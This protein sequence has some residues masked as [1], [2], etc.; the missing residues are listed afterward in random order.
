MSKEKL[1]VWLTELSEAYDADMIH[2]ERA[3]DDLGMLT[4]ENQ[5]PEDIKASRDLAGKPCITINGMPQ[6][7]RQVTGQI[8]SMNPGVR[9]MAGDSDA[10]KDVAEILEGLIRQIEYQCDASS[11]YEGATESAA[12]CSIGHWRILTRFCDGDTFD[13][14]IEIKRIHNPFAV[15]WDP[16]A[17]DATRKDARYCYIVEDL[18]KEE[19]QKLY[20]GKSENPATDQH[21]IAMAGFW[22]KGE[23]VTIAERYW[24]EYEE[25]KIGLMADGSVVRNPTPPMNPVK[26]RTV[27]D[28]K[29]K[30]VKISGG[31][32]LEGP[33]DIAGP[34]IPVVAVVG[35][36]WHLGEATYRSS[37]IR[38]AKDPQILYNYARS[39]GAE[40]LGMQ[41][42]TPYMVTPKQVAGLEAIWNTANTV[43]APY[44]P[45][46][47]DPAAPAPQRIQPPVPS[48]AVLSE[49]QLA[50]E[51]MK[52]TTGIY[53][54]SLGN[55]S[56]ETSGVAINARK[57]ESQNSNSIY[58]DNMVKAVAHTGRILVAMIPKVYDTKRAVRILGEDDQEKI[59]VINDLMLTADGVQPVNDV[60]I[61]KYD[62]RIGV[63]PSYQ[64]KRQEASEGMMEFMSASQTGP[65]IA[66]LV[67]G[68][69]D[70]PDAD[71]VAERLRKTLPPELA[72]K[73]DEDKTPEQQQQAM[74]QQA[75]AQEQAAQQQHA[76][77]VGMREQEAKTAQAEANAAKAIAEAKL[78]ELELAQATGQVDGAINQAFSM[79]QQSV[80]QPAPYGAY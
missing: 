15:F 48:A 75:M 56:N 32:I 44:L 9:V 78:K 77:E 54:A 35:E 5:W 39:S 45:Y 58:A 60:T 12:A 23:T 73:D 33:S 8:R 21:K 41:T 29:V 10:S 49:I 64:T 55:Q 24:V 68:M 59:V 28:P 17:K 72:E 42:K 1:S 25:V 74:Q 50:G 13:Q 26:T 76:Q 57:E 46:N 61:G 34:Y 31:D 71:R 19:F 67:A 65:L 2:R 47:P 69:Q 30:W 37:V 6:F 36:E 18:P 7:V 40:L 38:F 4:G 27:K 70:W 14:E 79:G 3:E 80:P 52:R 51:D 66:D 16:H 22:T 53:D 62:V 20:P 63:G 11:I 43:A